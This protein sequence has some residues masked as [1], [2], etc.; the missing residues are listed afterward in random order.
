MVVGGRGRRVVGAE[1]AAA[2]LGVVAPVEVV[3]VGEEEEGRA[4][5]D[6]GGELEAPQVDAALE[7]GGRQ[8]R[9]V[10]LAVP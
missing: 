4:V 1:D 9:V 3:L 10:A 7:G 5:D 2:A 8:G 6:G